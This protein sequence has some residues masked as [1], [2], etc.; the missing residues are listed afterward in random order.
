MFHDLDDTLRR[1]L[2]DT[3]AP[4]ELRNAA[5]SF[6]TPDKNYAPAE[7]TVNLYLY[8]VKE[9]RELR[10]PLPITQRIGNGYVQRQSPLRVD[11]TYMVT[12]WSNQVGAAKI[13]EE[14]R[15]LG[16]ALLWLSRFPTVPST[17]W[18]GSLLNQ[19][20]TPPTLVAQMDN[21]KAAGEF[22]TALGTPPRPTFNLSVTIA[23]ELGLEEPAP[24]VL[25]H[26]LRLLDKDKP[27]LEQRW[28]Q[29]VG[30]VSEAANP[31]NF[32]DGAEV[33]LVETAQA[34]I[35]NDQGQFTF[36]KLPPGLYTLEVSKA[37]FA[38][39]SKAI[40]VPPAAADGVTAYDVAL[41]P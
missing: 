9:N 8:E 31:A 12:A 32:L 40:A 41:A 1:V 7:A 16:Q 37:G 18:Q 39:Q 34:V 23:M 26:D 33:Q 3:V 28:F 6:E 25:I 17:Y 13:V 35:T 38:N 21:N 2:D 20:F 4:I 30:R 27:S 5:V 36:S 19:P 14:H 10:D 24:A 15:L 29:I 22:W 11:C